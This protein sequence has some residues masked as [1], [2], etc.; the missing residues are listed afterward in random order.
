M[1]LYSIRNWVELYENN[2][3]RTVKDLTWVAIPN[4]HDGENFTNI[5]QH[6]KGDT[7][8]AAFVLMVQ[9]ASKCSPRGTL[10]RDN[11]TPHTDSS[12]SAKCRAPK[13]WFC[14]AL[15]YLEKE[16][17]W[18]DV[19]DFAAPEQLPIIV[20]T[21]SCQ[22]G[23]EEG[24]EGKKEGNGKETVET[25]KIST[26]FDE[27]NDHHDLTKCLLISDKRRTALNQR[28][29]DSFFVTHWRDA[30]SRIM[31][32]DFCMGRNAR[33]WKANFDWFIRPDTIAKIMEGKYDNNVP[34]RQLPIGSL[35]QDATYDSTKDE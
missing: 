26:V 31:K 23:D 32:S 19:K 18:L 15:E 8:F 33:G 13:E 34:M 9:V 3:S 7:I 14:F 10:I 22:A 6:K 24:K 17:D 12:L 25:L 4:R 27:W 11:G 21:A 29:K 16:T 5:M 20:P 30:L 1:K 2:R 35:L 28:A